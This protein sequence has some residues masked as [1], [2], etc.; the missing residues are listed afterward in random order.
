[1]TGVLKVDD[2]QDAGAN[3]IVSSN[4]SGTLTF[5]SFSAPNITA[6]TAIL[7]DASDGA[8][9]GSSSLEWSDIF[10][11]DAA[12]INLGDDQ[13]VTLTHVADTG[14]LLNISRKI[15]F[16]DSATFIHQ[17]SDGVMTVDGE[18]TID[19]NASTAVLVSND[20]KL[21]SDAAVLSFGADSEITLTHSADVGLILKHTATA[22]DKPINLILQTGETDMAAN[23]VIGKISWQAPDE[24]TGTDAILVSAAIQA[25]AEGDHSSSSN[26][27][28]LV[29]MTGASEAAAAKV[30]IT[31][32]GHLMPTADDSYDLG[33]ASLQWRNVYTGDLHLSNMTKDVGNS[34]DGTKGDWTIQ[35]GAEDLFLLNNNS[36]KKYK[37]NLTE[38]E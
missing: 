18:A 38:I 32:A 36:G 34:V 27:T 3:S 17:S 35:E 11:A 31:S 5:G 7:P 10:L 14:I 16:G 29:F 28:S 9:I 37:F 8:A 23:D 13:D 20:L 24:G 21:D 25:I 30:K 22:D 1:M 2:I 15:Q 6:S 26:A 33:S 19:L 12:V 4:G